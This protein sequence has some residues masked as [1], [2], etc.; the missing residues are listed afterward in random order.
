MATSRK[1]KPQQSPVDTHERFVQARRQLQRDAQALVA[2]FFASF[3]F[4][5]AIAERQDCEQLAK[6]HAAAEL[7]ISESGDAALTKQLAEEK[8]M[9][10]IGVAVG[11]RLEARAFDT[12]GGVR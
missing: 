3:D 8:A 11:Q 9:Y 12:T 7:R 6:K 10:A 1:R 5:G 2:D 4:L